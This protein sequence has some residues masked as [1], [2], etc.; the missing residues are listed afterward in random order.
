MQ[1]ATPLLTLNVL[2][3]AAL[4][5]QRFVAPGGTQTGAAGNAI[6][7]GRYSVTAGQSVPV[8]A[9]GTTYVEAGAAIAAGA[10]VESDASGRAV[11]RASGV[12][13]GRVAPGDPGA[14]SAGQFVE[15][16][17]FPN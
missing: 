10:L 5:G 13:L 17:L 9:I 3:A 12:A 11:T 7:V 1:N 16:V 4:T 6:G 15:I 2:A 8:D 14:A